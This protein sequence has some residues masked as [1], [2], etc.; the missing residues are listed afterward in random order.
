MNWQ[1]LLRRALAGTVLVC[2]GPA[3]ASQSETARQQS[4]GLVIHAGTVIA[5]PGSDVLTDQTI[6]VTDGRIAAVRD[7]FLDPTD[8]AGSESAIPELLDLRDAVVLPGLMDMHVHLS[9]EFG[10][11]GQ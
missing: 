8:V 5:V 11:E 3:L 7:G 9:M 6:F 2:L 1:R 10:V 4:G